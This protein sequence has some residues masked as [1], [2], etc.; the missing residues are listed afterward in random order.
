MSIFVISI[1]LEFIELYVELFYLILFKRI[2]L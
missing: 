2:M 1:Y